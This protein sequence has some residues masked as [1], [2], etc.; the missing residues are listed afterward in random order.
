MTQALSVTIDC[1]EFEAIARE[2]TTL[3]ERLVSAV[4]PETA[5]KLARDF[6]GFVSGPKCC[7]IVW[8]DINGKTI[9]EIECEPLKRFRSAL[10]T[11]VERHLCGP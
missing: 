10:R 7:E 4:S 11:A 9:G 2:C 8:R 1:A 3:I 5:R 6:D